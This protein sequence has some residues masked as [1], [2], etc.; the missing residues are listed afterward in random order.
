MAIVHREAAEQLGAPPVRRTERALV[1]WAPVV[2]VA[3]AVVLLLA[4]PVAA[5]LSADAQPITPRAPAPVLPRLT[6]GRAGAVAP[7]PRFSTPEARAAL[8]RGHNGRRHS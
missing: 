6:G 3:F 8:I 1:R 7:L 2:L 4:L 5:R